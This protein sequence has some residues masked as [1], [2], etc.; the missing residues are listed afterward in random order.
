MAAA[1]SNAE[2]WHMRGRL[3]VGARVYDEQDRRHV[4]RLDAV[5]ASGVHRVT[6]DNGTRADVPEGRVR[7]AGKGE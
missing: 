1:R 3:P 6:F 2:S 7:R 4:G 5:F